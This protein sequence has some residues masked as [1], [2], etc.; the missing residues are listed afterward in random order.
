MG[1]EEKETVWIRSLRGMNEFME[2]FVSRLP[3]YRTLGRAFGNEGREIVDWDRARE[4]AI[5]VAQP[6]GEHDGDQPEARVVSDFEAL[7]GRSE[8]LVR[9]YSHLQPREP[10]GPLLVL[11]RPGWID[12]NLNNF[13]LLFEPLAEGYNQALGRIEEQRRRSLRVS[14]RFTQGLLTVQL[15]MVIGYLARNVLG[16]FDLGLPRLEN[17]G[18]LYIVYPNLLRAEKEMRLV[19]GDFR[20][21]ITLHEVT[22]AFEFAAYPWIRDYLKSLMENYFKSVSLRLEDMSLRLRLSELRDPG[23]LNEI[24]NQGGLMSV[25]HTPEQREMLSRIQ[26]FMSLVEGYSNLIM[27]LVGSDILPSFKEMSAAFRHRRDSKSR[28]ERFVEQMLGFDLKLQQYQVGEL[29]CREVVEKKSLD[30]LNLAWEREENLPSEEEIRHAFLWME[31][32][33]KDGKERVQRHRI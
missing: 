11:D 2:G 32:M 16:Q 26:A 18:K 21:W 13:R 24:I 31:R 7:L 1:E 4:I 3:L 30:F 8:E 28:A 12:T 23:R 9:S 19:P 14:R 33:E 6:E 27:D 5:M 20:F 17:T 22:H 25:V 15:G 29:F 10:V